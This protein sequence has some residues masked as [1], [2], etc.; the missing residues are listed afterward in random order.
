MADKIIVK[1]YNNE[2]EVSK[3]RN[4][5]RINKWAHSSRAV[6]FIMVVLEW[7]TIPFEVIFRRDLGERW[8]TEVNFYSGGALIILCGGLQWML[9]NIWPKAENYLSRIFWFIHPFSQ[10]YSYAWEKKDPFGDIVVLGICYVAM[11]LYHLFKI[12]WRN[13]IGKPIHSFDDGTPR[14]YILWIGNVMARI[15]NILFSPYMLIF[16]WAIP[17]EQRKSEPYPKLINDNLAFTCTIVEPCLVFYYASLSSEV[18]A[19]WCYISGFALLVHAHWRETARKSKILDLQDSK[20]EAQ[21]MRERKSN[22]LKDKTASEK[23]QALKAQKIP[24]ST[25]VP[26]V[27]YPNLNIIIDEMNR[28]REEGNRGASSQSDKAIL[29]N[30]LTSLTPTPKTHTVQDPP[31]VEIENHDEK[32][33]KEAES[34]ITDPPPWLVKA[35]LVEKMLKSSKNSK[36]LN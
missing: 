30:I 23:S 32:E 21:I 31:K 7:F 4:V 12:R 3:S 13:Q 24:P 6:N 17:S 36:P 15:V 29:S 5:T 10:S 9:S 16:Y 20:I 28:Q 25:A 19:I 27:K 2:A 35:A 26:V 22:A 11:G 1:P 34:T 18:T 8:F 14:K 33:N